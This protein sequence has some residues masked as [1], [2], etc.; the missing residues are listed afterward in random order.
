MTLVIVLRRVV[1]S[2]GVL[3]TCT[4]GD[5]VR[6]TNPL[7]SEVIRITKMRENCLKQWDE[8]WN[9]LEANNQV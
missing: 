4:L 1:G 3:K 9:C 8:H 7:L 2:P 6:A 5:R